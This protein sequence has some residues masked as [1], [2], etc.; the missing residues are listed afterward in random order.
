MA[1]SNPLKNQE[2]HTAGGNTNKP[3][4]SHY[5]EKKN[6]IKPSLWNI[7][8]VLKRVDK[9]SH[10]VL[11]EKAWASPCLGCPTRITDLELGENKFKN[12]LDSSKRSG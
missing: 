5:T 10:A 7:A 8:R 4:F 9:I 2:I 12:S 11:H 6:S 1:I 3:P